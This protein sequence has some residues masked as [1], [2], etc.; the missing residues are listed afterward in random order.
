[1]P[2]AL[3]LPGLDAIPFMIDLGLTVLFLAELP[4]LPVG[5]RGDA[6]VRRVGDR[7]VLAVCV[8]DQ[9]VE[10][11]LDRA[12]QILVHSS[13]LLESLDSQAAPGSH[14]EYDPPEFRVLGRP[15]LEA[16]GFGEAQHRRIERKDLSPNLMDVLIA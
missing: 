11:L 15:R 7:A 4:A 12:F 14:T 8:G 5:H 3:G 9:L 1:M 6:G 13:S 16:E 2:I 10:D